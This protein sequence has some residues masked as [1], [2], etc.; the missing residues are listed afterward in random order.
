M[1]F[2]LFR[3][4]FMTAFFTNSLYD[5]F[6]ILHFKAFGHLYH[7]DGIILKAVCLSTLYTVEMNMANVLLVM[8]AAYAIFLYARTIVYVVKQVVV[9]KKLQ[10]PEYA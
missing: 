7:G 4:S 3:L 8:T 9:S 5:V 6:C 10:C 2:L 1:V